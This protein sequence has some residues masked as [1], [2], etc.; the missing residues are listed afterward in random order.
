M[1]LGVVEERNCCSAVLTSC[2]K[3]TLAQLP[4]DYA[5]S[6]MGN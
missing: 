1:Q 6:E 4:R 5:G 2:A 3:R